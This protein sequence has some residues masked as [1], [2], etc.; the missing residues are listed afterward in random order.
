MPSLS[1]LLSVLW[2]QA[3]LF[4]VKAD[5]LSQEVSTPQQCYLHPK[6]NDHGRARGHVILAGVKGKQP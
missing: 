6:A 2:V 4:T 5:S 1:S 3:Y